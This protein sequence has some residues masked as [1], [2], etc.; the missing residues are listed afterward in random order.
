MVGMTKEER[1]AFY[2]RWSKNMEEQEVDGG[3]KMKDIKRFDKYYFGKHNRLEAKASW[4]KN[5]IQKLVD[6]YSVK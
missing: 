3:W 4:Y 2:D 6:E 1:F 5:V